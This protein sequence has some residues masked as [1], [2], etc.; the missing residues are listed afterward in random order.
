MLRLELLEDIVK[1]IFNDYYVLRSLGEG[2]SKMRGKSLT[3]LSVF[4]LAGCAALGGVEEREKIYG[5]EVPIIKES[6]ASKQVR[7]GENWRVYLNAS[8]PGGD[9]N[10]ILCSIDFQAGLQQPYPISITKIEKDE[11]KD[12]SGYLYLGTSGLERPISIRMSVT[13][14]DKAGHFSAPVEFSLDIVQPSQKEREIRREEPPRG[15]FQDKNL[16]PI[17]IVL[18]SDIG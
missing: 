8:D 2:G 7:M 17:M 15:I 6:F 16:G 5:K 11:Q 18:T 12:L 10:Q 9:M 4:L 1:G 14:K 13:I 3:A